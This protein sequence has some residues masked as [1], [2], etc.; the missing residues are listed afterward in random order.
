[1][2]DTIVIP[3]DPT[4]QIILPNSQPYFIVIPTTKFESAI[5]NEHV[6]FD[7][8][9]FGVL[10]TYERIKKKHYNISRDIV[11]EFINRCK[12]CRK[13]GSHCKV[14]KGYCSGC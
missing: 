6:G 3:K 4:Q 2:E 13:V 10:G 5:L 7:G 11:S 1:M 14:Q 8:S 9:H 12:D